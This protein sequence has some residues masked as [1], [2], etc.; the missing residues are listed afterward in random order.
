METV[1]EVFKPDGKFDKMVRLIT[2]HEE[3]INDNKEDIRY[4]RKDMGAFK[5]TLYG[6][7]FTVFILL[8]GFVLDIIKRR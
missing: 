7:V 4:T 2:V 5:K 3:R 6:V 1:K 8:I